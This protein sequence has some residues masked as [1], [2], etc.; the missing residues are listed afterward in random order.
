M[1]LI[2]RS[3]TPTFRVING[4]FIH[5]YPTP[6][7]SNIEVLE[8]GNVEVLVVAGGGSGGTPSAN[9]APA[10]GGGGGEVAYVSSFNISAGNMSFTVGAGGTNSNGGNSVFGSIQTNG[11][12]MGGGVTSASTGGSGGGAARNV[13]TSAASVKLYASGLGNAGGPGVSGITGAAGGGGAAGVGGTAGG[14]GAGV[15]GAGYATSNFS[16]SSEVFGSG[17]GGGARGG[18]D[19]GGGNGGINA[20]KGGGAETTNVAALNGGNATNGFG[21]GG[22]G[23]GVGGNTIA[24][25][26]NGGTGGSGVVIIKYAAPPSFTMPVSGEFKLS[27]LISVYSIPISTTYSSN[28]SVG[29]LCSWTGVPSEGAIITPTSLS[30]FYGKTG[31]VVYMPYNE[32]G[33]TATYD[34]AITM[35]QGTATRTLSSTYNYQVAGLASWSAVRYRSNGT[36]VQVQG[37]GVLKTNSNISVQVAKIL[38]FLKATGRTVFLNVNYACFAA[39]VYSGTNNGMTHNIILNINGVSTTLYEATFAT[40]GTVTRTFDITPYIANATSFAINFVFNLPN[41]GTTTLDNNRLEVNR[42]WMTVIQTT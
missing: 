5:V 4:Y 36:Q 22:G 30:N 25:I 41:S 2:N 7:T 23:G 13:L 42:V 15:G 18:G 40:G 9:F 6:G 12:G 31:T 1:V 26:G 29:Q 3:N 20:G 11:G 19:N 24:N 37:F 14:V 17:G 27:Q 38:R 8:G 33:F 21:G 35:P 10:G 28:V 32:T 16:F 34:P 39:N